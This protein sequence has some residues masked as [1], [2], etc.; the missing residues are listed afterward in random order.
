MAE[1]AG[2]P[3]PLKSLIWLIVLGIVLWYIIRWILGLFGAGDELQRKAV[4]LSVE[5]G[6]TV[7]VSIEGGLMKRTETGVPLYA[8]DK[9]STGTKGH[10]DLA[11][12]D[13]T[14]VRLDESTDLTI[15]ESKTGTDTS[16]IDLTL[17]RGSV[18]LLSPT[19]HVF[20]GSITRT[21]A[22]PAMTVTVPAHAEA[23][24]SASSLM[25]F[26]SEGLGLSVAVKG[27]NTPIVIGEG[28]KFALPD[29]ADVKGDLY[30]YR[31]ALGQETSTTFIAD[32][33]GTAAAGSGAGVKADVLT[34]T[35]PAN[36]AAISEASVSVQGK[37]TSAVRK[38]RVNGVAV[39]LDAATSTFSQSLPLD[40]Q[41]ADITVD[42][43]DAQDAVLMTVR[44]SVHKAAANAVKAP[45]ISAPAKNGETYTTTEN[46][47][48]L[49]GTNATSAAGIMVNEYRLQLF[50]PGK[51]TW[52]YLASARLG[53]MKVGTNVFNVYALDSAGN[54]SDP[55]TVTI[56]YND[57]TL[58]APSAGSGSSA[59]AQPDETTLPQNAPL[60]PG[61]LHVTGPTAGTAHTATGGEFLIEGTT[62][63][64]TASMW[65]NGYKLQLYVAGKTTW[66]YIASTAFGNLKKGANTYT[67][68]ARDAKNQIVDKVIY[69]VTY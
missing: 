50:T 59:P 22:T 2:F 30:A 44:R 47:V 32:S 61:S 36:N 33:R 48:V 51:G 28:Q 52:S 43:L 65:V 53:N 21:I 55:A 10:G 39:T 67:I 3:R 26:S 42:A 18:W 66:N 1:P 24:I 38:V 45:S 6:S 56:I 46:E 19:S 49:R 5:K 8:G 69:T 9:V 15:D 62:S 17:E 41:S 54:K 25:V 63:S 27:A 31:S 60:N 7:N 34:L 11:F 68:I 29:G 40:T 4:A 13:G 12:F 37:V 57:G 64:S 14:K 35:S 16:T 20:S 58:V 23:V